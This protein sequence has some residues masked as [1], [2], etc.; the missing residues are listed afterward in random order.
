[1][2]SILYVAFIVTMLLACGDQIAIANDTG[3][4]VQKDQQEELKKAELT[5]REFLKLV[6]EE[7]HDR[8]Y[9]FFSIKLREEFRKKHGIKN[10]SG[11]RDYVLS[12]ETLWSDPEILKVNMM[13]SQAI[14]ALV[15]M[16]LD[17]T[18]IIEKYNLSFNMV[19]EEGKWKIDNWPLYER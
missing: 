6:E 14:Q 8:C 5:L 18:G 9:D 16:T 3:V 2:R 13:G 4:H 11:Y 15:K 17:E 1:M 7:K 10:P 12:I 19:K